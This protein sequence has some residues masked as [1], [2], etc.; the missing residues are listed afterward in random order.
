MKC[1]GV[2]DWD[3]H[4]ECA[5][6]RTS[7]RHWW[8]KV[9]NR[10]DG[11]GLARLR[12][13]KSRDSIFTAWIHIIQIASKMPNRGLLYKGRP[14]DAEDIAL[15]TGW[16]PEIYQLAFEVLV[17]PKIGWL[18]YDEYETLLTCYQRVDT[19]RE[20]KKEEKKKPKKKLPTKLPTKKPTKTTEL[21]DF[22]APLNNGIF[23]KAW[24]DWVTH[25]KQIKKKLT[26]LAVKKQMKALAEMGEQRAVRAIEYSIANG[27][28]G[29]FEPKDKPQVS[30][31]PS[32]DCSDREWN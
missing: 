7:H 31:T 2:V 26:P 18:V 19:R 30:A 25:R 20:E 3:E 21:P 11:S 23:A 24:E 28:T 17:N 6:T 32:V 8:L 27:W 1:Y 5:Q 4:F 14:L 29:I 13:H 15:Q 16:N 22:P 10:F 9:P 12:L